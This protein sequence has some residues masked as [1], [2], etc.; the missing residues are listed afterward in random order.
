MNTCKQCGV[1]TS[2]PLFCGLSCAGKYQ[3]GRR[4][5]LIDRRRNCKQCNEEFLFKSQDHRFCSRSCSAKYN[6]V[7][8]SRNAAGGRKVPG[9]VL[10][11][12]NCSSEFVKSKSSSGKYCSVECSRLY[13]SEIKIKKWLS[14]EWSGAVSAGLSTS[15]RKYLI[16][17]AGNRCSECGW[18][19]VNPV[20]NKVPL[21]VDH[22]DGNCHNNRPENLRVICPNCHSLSPNYKALNKGSGRAYRGKY[23][24]FAVTEQC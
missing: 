9:S 14:G 5:N 1:E 6:N 13:R 24:Q 7:G 17:Q 10:R 12:Q 2:N 15:I 22:I 19:S 21:E 8:I 4:A 16:V 11:C 20:T 18:N 3:K 23:D